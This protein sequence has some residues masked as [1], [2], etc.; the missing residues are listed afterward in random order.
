MRIA[1]FFPLFVIVPWTFT[2]LL[3]VAPGT[4][5]AVYVVSTGTRQLSLL[6]SVGIRHAAATGVDVS[7]G[8]GSAGAFDGDQRW[9]ASRPCAGSLGPGPLCGRGSD[10]P[11]LLAAASGLAI[12]RRY[13]CQRSH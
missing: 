5:R 1:L 2:S 7:C 4:S 3:D 8:A 10:W 6:P 13:C 9:R 11:G 12:S